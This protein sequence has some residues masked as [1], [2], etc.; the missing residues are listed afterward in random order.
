MI[1]NTQWTQ[2]WGYYRLTPGRRFA[3]ENLRRSVPS[4]REE[5]LWDATVTSAR[6]VLP[7]QEPRSAVRLGGVATVFQVGPRQFIGVPLKEPRDRTR[8]A[9][10]SRRVSIATSLPQEIASP[11]TVSS[12]R[13]TFNQEFRRLGTISAAA[14]PS[15]RPIGRS[16]LSSWFPTFTVQRVRGRTFIW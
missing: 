4:N 14:R 6:T 16:A 3:H 5:P 1:L 7:S 10:D 15:D 8:H 9:I 2:E 13:I 11:E 12:S